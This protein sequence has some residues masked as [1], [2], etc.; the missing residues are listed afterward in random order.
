M[1]DAGHPLISGALGLSPE[2]AEL[3]EIA[4]GTHIATA[5]ASDGSITVQVSADGTVHRWQLSDTARSADSEQLIGTMI[6]LIGQ[7]RI[8][9]R[10]TVHSGFGLNLPAEILASRGTLDSAPSSNSATPLPSTVADIDTWDDDEDYY[11]RGK[12]RIAAD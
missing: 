12:S 5:S 4:L 10:N 6:E 7:A 9:A 3:F 11:H 1:S 2:D 8:E